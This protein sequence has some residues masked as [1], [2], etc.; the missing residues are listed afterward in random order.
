[1]R[2]ALE[3]VRWA[4]QQNPKHRSGF[5]LQDVDNK[6][7]WRAAQDEHIE[8]RMSIENNKPDIIEFAD[9]MAIH[10]HQMILN[11]WDLFDVQA[12]I[13]EKLMMRFEWTPEQRAHLELELFAMKELAQDRKLL[14]DLGVPLTPP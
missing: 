2:R 12:A 6:K 7:L 5:R 3:V 4:I 1:M 10:L 11:N 8:L 9:A 13:V 14:Q